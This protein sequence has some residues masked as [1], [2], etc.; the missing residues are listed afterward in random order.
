M[1]RPASY[2]LSIEVVLPKTVIEGKS[3]K[4]SYRIKNVSSTSFPGG[5]IF[6]RVF[7]PV[8]GPTLFVNHPIPIGPLEPNE[9]FELSYE[10]TPAAS[11]MM[12]FTPTEDTFMSGNRVPIELRLANGNRLMAGVPIGGVRARSPEE[13]SEARAV[14]IAAGS[15]VILMIFQI[16]DWLIRYLHLF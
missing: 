5:L 14:R 9:V 10:E 4:V 7:W 2:E 12:V 13:V 3:F 11:G 15:L 16:M 1:S 6:V 8:L